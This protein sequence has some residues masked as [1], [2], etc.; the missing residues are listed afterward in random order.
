MLLSKWKITE[1]LIRMLRYYGY[2]NN[3]SRDKH[4]KQNQDGMVP[5]ILESD[6]LF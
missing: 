4:K 1:D 6:G 2:Y 5:S 3:I